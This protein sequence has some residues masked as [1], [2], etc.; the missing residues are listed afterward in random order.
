MLGRTERRKVTFLNNCRWIFPVLL[1]TLLKASSPCSTVSKILWLKALR[2]SSKKGPR[3]LSCAPRKAFSLPS[4]LSEISINSSVRA[5]Q[6]ISIYLNLTPVTPDFLLVTLLSHHVTLLSRRK[7]A[8]TC[9]VVLC[10]P[11]QKILH[12]LTASFQNK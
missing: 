7:F 3:G 2:N 4:I 12:G 8:F 6:V 11:P 9:S 1:K 10:L 5:E